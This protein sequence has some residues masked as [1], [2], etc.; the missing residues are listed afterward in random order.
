MSRSGKDHIGPYRLLRLIQA[1]KSTQVWEAMNS[2]DHR[3]VALK[4]LRT[5]Y[6]KDKGHLA[7]M[8]H[9]FLVGQTLDHPHVNKI[10]DLD[11]T[12]ATPYLTM[13]YFPAPNLKSCV[14]Q[15]LPQLT[16]YLPTIIRSAAEAIGHMHERGW[17]HRDIKPEN[18][19]VAENGDLR[20]I[21]FAIAQRVVKSGMLGKLFGSK[22]AVMGTRSYMSPEQIRGGDI[23]FR[24]DIYSF[25]CTLYEIVT[26][27][28]PYT[29]TN[30][31]DL[32]NRHLK[33]QIPSAAA[34]RS[35][36]TPEFSRLIGTMLAK[37]PDDRPAS[38]KKFLESLDHMRI[39]KPA[40]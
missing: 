4:I 2:T 19:L 18:L 39:L 5:D 24:A 21:D 7:S 38:M 3:R 33:S 1:G 15:N 6:A 10:L 28:P 9:E 40:V 14:R 30:A 12:R 27:K 25:G 31:D 26:G 32:L 22:G 16:K 11:L 23:D 20:L 13:E 36:L 29:G 35:D 34:S 17:I 37:Q 8:K